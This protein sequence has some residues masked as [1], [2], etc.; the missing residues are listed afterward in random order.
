MPTN[1]RPFFRDRQPAFPPRAIEIF[2]RMVV[3]IECT[4]EDGSKTKCAGCEEYHALDRELCDVLKL[5]P[6][7]YPALISPDTPNLRGPSDVWHDDGVRLYRALAEAA[8]VE[9]EEDEP[10]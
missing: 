5:K 7:Q 8:G 9:L 2:K 10:C 1:R 4:C 6:W 3:D